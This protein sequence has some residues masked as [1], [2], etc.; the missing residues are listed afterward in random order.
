[1]VS[2]FLDWVLVN[3]E[4]E[5]K[6]ESSIISTLKLG[7]GLKIV[8]IIVDKSYNKRNMSRIKLLSRTQFQCDLMLFLSFIFFFV[9]AHNQNTYLLEFGVNSDVLTFEGKSKSQI[10]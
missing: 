7:Q 6:I 3:I 1:L 5:S 4:I 9:L 10:I 8:V 2:V